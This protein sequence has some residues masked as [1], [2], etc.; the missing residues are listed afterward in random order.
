M[1]AIFVDTNVFIDAR[2]HTDEYSVLEYLME[3]PHKKHI[4]LKSIK[5]EFYRVLKKFRKNFRLKIINLGKINEFSLFED[6]LQY[7]AKQ[8]YNSPLEHIMER[9][10][11]KELFNHRKKLFKIVS[12]ELDNI[13]KNFIHFTANAISYTFIREDIEFE[14]KWIHLKYGNVFGRR[15]ADETHFCGIL[16]YAKDNKNISKIFITKD[17]FFIRKLD[18]TFL[19]YMEKR[20]G[21]QIYS[22]NKFFN[23][24]YTQG[25]G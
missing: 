18:K 6:E 20:R 2:P 1:L 13:E 4:L 11:A 21:I 15:K 8:R 7:L 9:Y 22:P 5:M 19:T 25:Y 12:E 14:R 17:N 24:F 23:E 3:D 10:T 16:S